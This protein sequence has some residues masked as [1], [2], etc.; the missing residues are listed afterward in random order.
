MIKSRED[1]T[2]IMGLFKKKKAEEPQPVVVEPQG[3]E[4]GCYD[5]LTEAAEEAA[6][7]HFKWVFMGEP[8]LY[9]INDLKAMAEIDDQENQLSEGEKYVVL[10]DGSIGLKKDGVYID[11][12]FIPV[13]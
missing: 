3:Q 2:N 6:R 12:L 4:V 8:D 13:R 5:R 9:S 11:W 10:S 7:H 1:I